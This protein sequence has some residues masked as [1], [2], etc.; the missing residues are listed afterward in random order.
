MNTKKN[1]YATLSGGKI[2][3]PFKSEQPKATTK[4]GNDLRVGGKK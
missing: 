4:S 3:A 2:E 1:P